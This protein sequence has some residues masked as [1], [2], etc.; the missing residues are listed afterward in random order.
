MYDFDVMHNLPLRWFG[1]RNVPGIPFDL[2]GLA[3]TTVKL[4]G[5]QLQIEPA[6]QGLS[7]TYTIGGNT[8][9][10]YEFLYGECLSDRLSTGLQRLLGTLRDR[11]RRVRNAILGLAVGDRD[12]FELPA[13]SSPLT[14]LPL[15]DPA[16]WA[17]SWTNY[18]DV[19]DKA[20]SLAPRW[21]VPLVDAEAA[22][23][24]FWPSLA[25]Y[26]LAYNLLFLTKLDAASVESFKTLLGSSWNAAWSQA[27]VDGR[28]YVIDLRIFGD[29]EPQTIDGLLRFT[30][31][32]VTLLVQD[33][34]TLELQPV[35]VRVAGYRDAGAQVFARGQATD[36]TWLFALLAA[37]TS[38]TVYGIWIGHV[39]HWHI[40]SGAMQM[41]MY[42][43][44]P[45]THPLY[46]LL[47]PQSNYLIQFD[48]LLLLLWKFIAP[49]TSFGTASSFLHLTNAFAAGRQ[50]FDDD[51]LPTL[52]RHGITE[53]DFSETASWDRYPIVPYFL[54]MWRAAERYVS[55]FVHTTYA[56][57]AAVANDRVL[58]RW[59]EDAS[60]EDDGN[61][62]GLPNLRS[63]A[64]LQQVLTSLIYRLTMHGCS[65]LN[66][67]ANPG[68]TWVANFPPCLQ[69]AGIPRPDAQLTTDQLLQFLPHTG[70]IGLM[71]TFYYTF[72]FS[73]PYDP[74]MPAGGPETN[75]F[76]PGGMSDPR[77]Q[78]LVQFREAVQGI[79]LRFQSDPPQPEQWPLNIET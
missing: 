69:H 46:L 49:P 43:T 78:A 76:F 22:S 16:Q 13:E 57:D 44:V 71:M 21:T 36:S 7:N 70:T 17:I 28:L 23:N 32:T 65:R 41:A 53:R 63:R 27:A 67:A 51:P 33:A 8:A 74:F 38:A 54:D 34:S 20:R 19:Y 25:N 48:E 12:F 3:D 72:V 24:E 14:R 77:N 5:R 47:K 42:N 40:V 58:P 75:L 56:S 18:Q 9:T 30:P 79:S 55:V 11:P 45:V 15:D 29:F 66:H 37:R 60:D 6:K 59:I 61:L 4:L 39:Y 31:S 10:G 35:A 62:R 64:E 52:A 73:A 68:L 26:G 2:D 1:L 50:Y